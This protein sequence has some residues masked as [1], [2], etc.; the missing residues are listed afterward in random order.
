MGATAGSLNPASLKAESDGGLTSLVLRRLSGRLSP[1]A[2]RR[3]TANRVT[4]IAAIVGL[5]GA[6][7]AAAGFA[8]V[9]A[10][11]L[12]AFSVLSCVDGEVARLRQETSKLGDFF[13]TTSDRIVEVAAIGAAALLLRASWTCDA[14]I[15]AL[16]GASLMLT[17][18][19]EKFRSAFGYDYPKRRLEPWFLYLTSGSDARLLFVA[20]AMVIGEFSR[21]PAQA[22]LA[23]L[24]VCAWSNVAWRLYAVASLTKGDAI[25]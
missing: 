18:T 16:L 25:T 7:V 11:L 8:I 4:T 17:V 19:S 22:V 13:D 24:A 5:S 15:V 20:G 14:V 2:A 9:G 3:L 10:V 12:Q 21:S 6:V 23:G 1:F